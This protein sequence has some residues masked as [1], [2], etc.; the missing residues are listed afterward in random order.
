MLLT[1]DITTARNVL[2][3]CLG[4]IDRI[5]RT[6]VQKDQSSVTELKLV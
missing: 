1:I 6:S 5:S 2:R 3:E 4:E